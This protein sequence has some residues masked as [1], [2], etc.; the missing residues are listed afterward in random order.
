MVQMDYGA[1][2]PPSQMVFFIWK[3]LS[4]VPMISSWINW[5]GEQRG[6][7]TSSADGNEKVPFGLQVIHLYPQQKYLPFWSCQK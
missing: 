4:F 3:W 5:L 2:L 1:V 7:P 6:R